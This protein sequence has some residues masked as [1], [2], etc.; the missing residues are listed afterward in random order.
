LL[1][2]LFKHCA[3]PAFGVTEAP[4]QTRKR[5]NLMQ[6]RPQLCAGWARLMSM[7]GLKPT[8][9]AMAGSNRLM[10]TAEESIVG[11]IRRAWALLTSFESNGVRFPEPIV[12]SLKQ[13]TA[14]HEQRVWTPSV[15]HDFRD[16]LNLLDSMMSRRNF[17]SVPRRET[18]EKGN[19]CADGQGWTVIVR[20]AR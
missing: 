1:V 11:D 18:V 3:K 13:A 12:E 20:R 4:L 14:A 10:Q 8:G 16:T 7:S 17:E 6:M 9:A 5:E 2:R 15:Y 19:Q